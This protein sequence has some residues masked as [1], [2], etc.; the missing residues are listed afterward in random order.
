MKK[1]LNENKYYE[2]T[3]FDL[4]IY[5]Y[6]LGHSL[7]EINWKSVSIA[8]FV[9]ENAEGIHEDISKFWAG[10]AAV[11]A[12]SLLAAERELKRRMYGTRS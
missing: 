1:R 11:D 4:A 10:E 7:I 5:I 2:T 6:S 12:K 3:A 8:S 9:F